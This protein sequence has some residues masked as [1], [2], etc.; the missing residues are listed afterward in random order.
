MIFLHHYVNFSLVLNMPYKRKTIG[1][2][3]GEMTQKK[4]LNKE[5]ERKSLSTNQ[6][7]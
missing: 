4:K 6:G 1:L 5:K 7:S 3:A 2:V